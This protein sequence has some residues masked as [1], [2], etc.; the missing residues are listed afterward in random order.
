VLGNVAQLYTYHCID[1]KL[2]SLYSTNYGV[3]VYSI[4]IVDKPWDSV[5]CPKFRV[6]YLMCG[7]IVLCVYKLSKVLERCVFDSVVI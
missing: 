6:V 7:F 4:S 1:R 3:Q 2:E 5:K